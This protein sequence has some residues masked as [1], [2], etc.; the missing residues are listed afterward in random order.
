MTEDDKTVQDPAHEL[1][2]VSVKIP[3]F[4]LDRPEIWF[5]QV[6]AQ[7]KIIGIISEETKFNYLVSQLEPKHVEN[8]WDI[9]TST[10]ATKYAESKTRLL[11]LFKESESTR[12]KKLLT[13]IDLGNLKPSQLL[14]KLKSVATSDVSE[15]L[16]K[17]LWLEKLPD[18]M[19]NIILVSDEELPKL[20]I[21]A[22]KISA[23]TPSKDLWCI[24]S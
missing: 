13:G 6:E 9:I 24:N 21:M 17:T 10:S 11:D 18:S 14:Q 15:N 12:I 1:C 22:D 23:M 16:T 19:R 8:I 20:A 5:F 3:P 2:K 7:F 4:W